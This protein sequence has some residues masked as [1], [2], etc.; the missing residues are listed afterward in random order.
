MTKTACTAGGSLSG[1]GGGRPAD[2]QGPERCW[3]GEG[4]AG[5]AS[6]RGQTG[7]QMLF[8]ARYPLRVRSPNVLKFDISRA[9]RPLSLP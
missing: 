8:D 9:S 7:T 4:A 6:A 3:S 1:S 2:G 5:A